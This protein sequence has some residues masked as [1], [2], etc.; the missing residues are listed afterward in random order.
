MFSIC[1]L[2]KTSSHIYFNILFKVTFNSQLR[3][4]FSHH[5]LTLYTTGNDNQSRNE[6]GFVMSRNSPDGASHLSLFDRSFR[7][8]K[9]CSFEYDMEKY[10]PCPMNKVWAFRWTLY[11][12]EMCCIFSCGTKNKRLYL[13]PRSSHTWH[14]CHILQCD[15]GWYRY[16]SPSEN[17]SKSVI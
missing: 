1:V 7:I 8:C 11:S 16:T 14:N 13:L 6:I 12:L 4:I 17:L 3:A 10:N 15:M 9:R 5:C 2:H